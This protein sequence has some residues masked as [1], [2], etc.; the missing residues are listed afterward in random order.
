MSC[1]DMIPVRKRGG[2]YEI[3]LIIRGTG[4]EAGKYC[5]LGGIMRKGESVT[6]AIRRL[7]E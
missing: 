2:K 7:G 1:V 3:G 6:Q 5:L 4:P